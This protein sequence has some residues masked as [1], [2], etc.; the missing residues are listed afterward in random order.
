M[1][2]YFIDDEKNEFVVDLHRT[3]VHSSN[4]VE[5]TFS[6]LENEKL[7]RTKNVYVRKLAGQYFVSTDN[8]RWKKLARQ[9]APNI[10]LNVNKV[11]QLFRGYKPSGLMGGNEGELLT[12]MPGKVVKILVERGQVVQKG[13]NL[14]I[15]E[16]MKMENEIKA[17]IDGMVKEIYVSEGQALE[18][19]FLMLEVGKE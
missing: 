3:V 19:G 4:L 17:P 6:A 1:R 16:A 2:N 13:D 11:Y 15:L 14:L 7:E 12:Q 10:M 9:D 8:K 5:F 18:N